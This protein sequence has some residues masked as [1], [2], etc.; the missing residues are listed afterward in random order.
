[1][2]TCNLRIQHIETA[3][4]VKETQFGEAVHTADGNQAIT[5]ES[6]LK[7]DSVLEA[8]NETHGHLYAIVMEEEKLQVEV[9]C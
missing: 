4:W 5:F 1:M 2:K 8:L 3:E 6:E 9:F 7:A